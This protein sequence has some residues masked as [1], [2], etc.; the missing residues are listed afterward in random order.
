MRFLH[1]YT[2]TIYGL[3]L[4]HPK[5][6]PCAFTGM[7]KQIH[8]HHRHTSHISSSSSIGKSHTYKNH[9]TVHTHGRGNAIAVT[10]ST[11]VP[12][13]VCVHT[14]CDNSYNRP[15]FFTE[16]WKK[17]ICAMYDGGGGVFAWAYLW[18][19]RVDLLDDANSVYCACIWIKYILK[20]VD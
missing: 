8:F 19:R 7:P 11:E 10:L 4:R 9:E 14:P 6:H 17:T 16:L 3:N 2:C 20:W 18:R 15:R 13:G 5:G 12:F 1:A